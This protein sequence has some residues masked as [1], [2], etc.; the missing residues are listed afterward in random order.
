MGF[1]E[2]FIDLLYG[3]SLSVLVRSGH[4]VCCWNYIASVSNDFLC[5]D[6][7]AHLYHSGQQP[8][9]LARVLPLCPNRCWTDWK[10]V[11][12]QPFVLMSS[13]NLLKRSRKV[14]PLNLNTTK[15]ISIHT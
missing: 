1:P 11:F 15:T 12:N 6:E 5:Q 9:F 3:I 10:L 4:H 13:L 8:C 2:V 14:R 7:C